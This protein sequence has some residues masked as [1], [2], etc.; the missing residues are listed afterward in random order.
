MERFANSRWTGFVYLASIS[1]T[2]LLIW[3]WNRQSPRDQGV[4]V[5]IGLVLAANIFVVAA[6]LSITRVRAYW[7]RSRGSAQK[8][9]QI[10]NRLRQKQAERDRTS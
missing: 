3:N 6:V 10:A 9:N 1:Y 5:L 8:D 7:R 2:G 4:F